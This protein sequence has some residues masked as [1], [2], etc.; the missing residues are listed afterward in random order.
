MFDRR[1]GWVGLSAARKITTE[2]WDG[3]LAKLQQQRTSALIGVLGE[4]LSRG[5]AVG[6]ATLRSP[7]L[8]DPS[9][10]FSWEKWAKGK[11]KEKGRNLRKTETLDGADIVRDGRLSR[12]SIQ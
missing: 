2:S 3:I 7:L 11:K 6:Q 5:D 1:D 12:Q 8:D 10:I 4:V 9:A